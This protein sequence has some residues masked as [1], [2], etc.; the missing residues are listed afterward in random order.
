MNSPP[1][2]YIL[3]SRHR[4]LCIGN[5]MWRWYM[6]AYFAYLRL[7]WIQHTRTHYCGCCILQ[8]QRVYLLCTKH[9][10]VC[11]S[12]YWWPSV[13]RHTVFV[14]SA[15]QY[16]KFIHIVQKYNLQQCLEHNHWYLC[17]IRMPLALDILQSFANIKKSH[18]D[19][20]VAPVKPRRAPSVQN[21][22]QFPWKCYEHRRSA[23]HM[24]RLLHSV[25]DQAL[26]ALGTSTRSLAQTCFR[27][28]F[29]GCV[30]SALST[31]YLT[32]HLTVL[33]HAAGAVRTS[34]KYRI[35]GFAWVNMSST[36]FLCTFV[37]VTNCCPA[38]HND[39]K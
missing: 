1:Y 15:I 21:R 13:L 12:M 2:I 22:V 29:H 32:D 30:R 37:T 9:C 24:Q 35:S 27:V 28:W 34:S 18:I 25:G 39:I 4:N 8:C 20:A 36:L 10:R 26:R 31:R 19:D 7:S 17:C 33:S 23:M 16:T 6:Y 38:S 3:G 14:F 11:A 5:S